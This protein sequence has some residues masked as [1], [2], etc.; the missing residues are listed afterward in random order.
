M[1]IVD[2]IQS[3][4]RTI[5]YGP[6]D[7]H[8]INAVDAGQLFV[9]GRLVVMD[10]F[11][12]LA[13]HL[14]GMPRVSDAPATFA[15]T[16]S[17]IEIADSPGS[18]LH[19]VG[20]VTATILESD[21][22]P[23]RWQNGFGEGHGVAVDSRNIVLLDDA[24][25]E[26]YRHAREREDGDPADLMDSMNQEPFKLVDGGLV[27]RCGEGDGVYDV[28][29]GYSADDRLAQVVVDL[30]TFSEGDIG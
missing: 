27:V 24:R 14:P 15:V 28:W 6:G 19:L 7:S 8:V 25:V 5:T 1:D 12:P 26:P 30:D 9:S 10:A 11:W 4:G 17:T 2:R 20:G 23:T 29:L 18:R 21:A 22:P 16:L 13:G 3:Y